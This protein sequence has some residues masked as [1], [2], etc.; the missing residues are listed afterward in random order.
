MDWTVIWEGGLW[1]DEREPKKEKNRRKINHQDWRN[2]L[3]NCFEF[4]EAL[5]TESGVLEGE[6]E[7]CQNSHG[8]E[9]IDGQVAEIQL[10]QILESESRHT[11]S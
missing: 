8:N 7:Y 6:K 11:S 1:D 9:G 10:N 3:N 2:S 5:K 4:E